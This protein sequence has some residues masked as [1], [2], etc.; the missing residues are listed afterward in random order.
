M[1]ALSPEVSGSFLP[2][3]YRIGS[4]GTACTSTAPCLSAMLF[5]Q[6]SRTGRCT[7]GRVGRQFSSSRSGPFD[8]RRPSSGVNTK[9]GNKQTTNTPTLS[10][11]NFAESSIAACPTTRKAP[12]SLPQHTLPPPCISIESSPLLR[13]SQPLPRRWH[14]STRTDN[15][16]PRLFRASLS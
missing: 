12:T 3:Q 9:F 2:E 11:I 8:T 10:N 14:L 1:L 13:H 4:R 7:A 5:P 16:V 15:P 6:R